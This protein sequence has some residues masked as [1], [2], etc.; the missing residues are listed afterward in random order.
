MQFLFKTFEIQCYMNTEP[1]R[2]EIKMLHIFKTNWS[3]ST[4][5]IVHYCV[6]SMGD[7][8]SLQNVRSTIEERGSPSSPIIREE[9]FPL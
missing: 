6:A 3:I 2:D 5:Y 4:I 7:G 8:I 9:R 1:I